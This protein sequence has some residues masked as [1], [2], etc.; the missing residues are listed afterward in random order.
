MRISDWSSDVCSSDLVAGVCLVRG[1][2]QFDQTA[3][4]RFPYAVC[5]AYFWPDTHAAPQ[6]GGL[7]LGADGRVRRGHLDL[8]APAQDRT[9][10]GALRGV[11]RDV[12]EC[13]PEIG[14]ATCRERVGR[15]G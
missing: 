8:A 4:A 15:Y 2:D 10:G 6:C 1:P 9:R 7:R 13:R 5:L 12:V 11:G 3:P 14:R